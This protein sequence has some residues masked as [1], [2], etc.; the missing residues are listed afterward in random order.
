MKIFRINIGLTNTEGIK[1]L[2]LLISSIK[3][4]YP[5]FKIALCVNGN[6]SFYSPKVDFVIKQTGLELPI[7]PPAGFSV[8]WK[9]YPPRIFDNSHEITVD[10]DI[11][12]L[13]RSPKIDEFLNSESLFLAYEGLYGLYGSYQ[14]NC[15]FNINSGI[16]GLP[17]IC[18]FTEKVLINLK[19]KW[20][21]YFDEQ[22]LIAKIISQEDSVLI[23]QQEI[24]IM[25]KD[26][27]YI[28]DKDGVHFV[29]LNRCPEHK[30]W[31][32]FKQ[33]IIKI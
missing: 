21:N 28:P 33:S 26:S 17:P 10:N 24:P 15:K 12:F 4:Y 11:I 2:T 31:D 3:R 32:Y 27:D 20:D 9:L 5:E 19:D 30:A 16:F 25:E 14:V 8:H 1:C 6:Q 13:K 23:T 22:G 29:G 7:V 18:N